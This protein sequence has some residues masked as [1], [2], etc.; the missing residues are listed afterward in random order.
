MDDLRIAMLEADRERMRA[1]LLLREMQAWKE[2][3]ELARQ[4]VKTHEISIEA[5]RKIVAMGSDRENKL[6]KD[7]KRT[8]D[9]NRDIELNLKENNATLSQATKAY[10][11]ACTRMTELEAQLAASQDLV[12]QLTAAYETKMQVQDMLIGRLERLSPRTVDRFRKELAH[13]NR[14]K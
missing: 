10:E 9:R 8:E 1:D 7:L 11:L 2:Q 12:K 13:G 6:L 14:A 4:Q 3:C 5:M